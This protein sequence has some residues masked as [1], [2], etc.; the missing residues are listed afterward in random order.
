MKMVSLVLKFVFSCSPQNDAF[1]SFNQTT[2]KKNFKKTL[3]IN[4]FDLCFLL[5]TK[6][7]FSFLDYKQIVSLKAVY[8]PSIVFF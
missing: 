7:R 1:V 5:L 8:L 6:F 2:S 3:L 4:P